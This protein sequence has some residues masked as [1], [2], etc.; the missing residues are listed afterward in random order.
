MGDFDRASAEQYLFFFFLASGKISECVE[1]PVRLTWAVEVSL[2]QQ[3]R[4]QSPTL[5]LT[6]GAVV[7][8]CPTHPALAVSHRLLLLQNVLA[9][10]DS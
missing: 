3:Y 10:S 4:E 5:N 9:V 7:G 1:S 8:P 6:L 2:L